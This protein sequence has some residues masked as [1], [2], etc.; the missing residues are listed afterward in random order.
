MLYQVSCSCLM[1]DIPEHSMEFDLRADFVFHVSST[2]LEG[3][4]GG[5]IPLEEGLEAC[6]QGFKSA[7]AKESKIIA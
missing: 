2:I 6:Q 1:L 5:V 4:S 3:L 7:V